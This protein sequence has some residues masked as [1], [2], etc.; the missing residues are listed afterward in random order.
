[1][2]AILVAVEAD[3]M[4]L[5]SDAQESWAAQVARALATAL[6]DEPNASMARELR[7]VMTSLVASSK[8]VKVDSVDEIAAARRARR[9]KIQAGS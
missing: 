6:D 5:S 3:L 7:S 1:M 8:S 9:A 2:G 4:R